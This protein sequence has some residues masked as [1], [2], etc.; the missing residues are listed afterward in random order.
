MALPQI[1]HLQF[2]LLSTIGEEDLPCSVLRKAVMDCGEEQS[3]PA[4]YQAMTRMERISLIKGRY[5]KTMVGE[6]II[7]EKYY[8]LTELGFEAINSVKRFYGI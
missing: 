2:L 4:F 6:Q 8:Q 3:G 5:Q 1:T 7:R